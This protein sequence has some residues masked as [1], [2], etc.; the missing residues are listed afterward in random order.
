MVKIGR[1]ISKILTLN[2]LKRLEPVFLFVGILYGILLVDWAL[3]VKINAFGIIPRSQSGLIGIVSAPF[4]H[5]N[6]SHLAS[7]TFPLVAMLITLVIFYEKKVLKLILGVVLL[8]GVLVWCFGREA[9]HIGASGLIY[10]LA[11]FLIAN[12]IIERKVMSIVISVIIGIIYGGLIYGV[13]PTQPDVSWEGHL[14]GAISGVLM[15]YVLGK[16]PQVKT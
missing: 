2:M 15:S 10:G 16:K 13:L 7:N 6:F 3:P 5:A 12:G 14:F 11:G 8:S 1:Y 9:N 4:L